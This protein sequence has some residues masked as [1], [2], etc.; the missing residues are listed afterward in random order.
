MVNWCNT[1]RGITNMD[2]NALMKLVGTKYN[3]YRITRYIAS[4]SYGDVFEAQ[5]TQTS[6]VVAL[7]FPTKKDSEHDD[8]ILMTEARVYK[9]ISNPACGV[10]NA[11]VITCKQQKVVVMDLLGISLE[12][13]MRE[14]TKLSIQT[15]VLLA[16]QM[17]DILKYIHSCGYI[18]RDIKPDNFVTGFNT[19]QEL[20]C[21]DYGL[22]KKYVNRNG[23]HIPFSEHRRFC[24]TAR[25]ASI[26]AHKQQEQSRKDDL[27]SL[28]YI[29]VYLHNG[30]LPWQGIQHKDKHERYKRIGKKKETISEEVLC[31][32]MPKEFCVFLKYVR[33]LDFDEKPH[34]TALRNMFQRLAHS[35]D[36]S[37]HQFEFC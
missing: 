36:C 5:D 20:Y 33:T 21:I 19:K 7:K 32:N 26:A 37:T 27:E 35:L 16:I 15:V 6:Q 9:H 23:R 12:T 34:Y 10:P 11:K 31:A 2:N 8:K 28:G 13:I 4:G 29:L 25:Y 30:A 14:H 3:K 24:G 22:A 18:H 17:I 1:F